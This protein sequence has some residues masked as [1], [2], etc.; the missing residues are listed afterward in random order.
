MDIAA[1]ATLRPELGGQWSRAVLH[2]ILTERR[3]VW[4]GSRSRTFKEG[5]FPAFTIHLA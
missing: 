3:A 1:F 2:D 5:D 4:G